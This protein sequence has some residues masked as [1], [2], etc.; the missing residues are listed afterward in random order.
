MRF[1]LVLLL[2]AFPCLAHD[3]T[4][5][6]CREAADMVMHFAQARDTKSVDK[7]TAMQQYDDSV[8]MVSVYPPAQRWFVEDDEDVA[9]LRGAIGQVFDN[10]DQSPEALATI[11]RAV[12]QTWKRQ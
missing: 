12:C 9:L 3:R 7:P 6:E 11:F 4:N 5:D 10:P 2:F 8:K 1:V